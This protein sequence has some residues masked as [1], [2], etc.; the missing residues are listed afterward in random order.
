MDCFCFFDKE[1]VDWL[2]SG[3]LLML[4]VRSFAAPSHLN[5]TDLRGTLLEQHI[6]SDGQM[7]RLI[8][9]RFKYTSTFQ[10]H[11]NVMNWP[12]YPVSHMKCGLTSS[13][14]STW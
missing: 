6:V 2:A 13:T 4:T 11:A 12:C 3:I 7:R 10:A 1:C 5:R 9:M 14:H 8:E